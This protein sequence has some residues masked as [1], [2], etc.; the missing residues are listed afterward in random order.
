MDSEPPKPEDEDDSEAYLTNLSAFNNNLTAIICNG[1]ELDL[2]EL[3]YKYGKILSIKKAEALKLVELS[4][5]ASENA[6]DAIRFGVTKL[7]IKKRIL[8]F[9]A[10]LKPELKSD[11]EFFFNEQEEALNNI[12]KKEKDN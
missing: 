3:L 1:S 8:Q 6:S 4:V 5:K 9:E 7:N 2:D 10:G 11:R 12:D